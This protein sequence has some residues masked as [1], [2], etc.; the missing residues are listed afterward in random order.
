MF[1]L[2]AAILAHKDDNLIVVPL[3]ISLSA[4]KTGQNPYF[5]TNFYNADLV[6]GGNTYVR[7]MPFDISSIVTDAT[8]VQ[9]L[10]ITVQDQKQQLKAIQATEGLAN[11]HL[12]V[13]EAWVDSTDRATVLAA[14][15]IATGMIDGEPELD[16]EADASTAMI[17]I[18][19]GFVSLV[20]NAPRRKY[21]LSCTHDFGDA[22]CKHVVTA[23]QTCDHRYT[24]CLNTYANSI[25]FGGC[26][27]ALAPGTK[28]AIGGQA[29]P[30]TLRTRTY[31]GLVIHE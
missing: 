22:R 5:W 21:Q 13:Y 4:E 7:T 23:G 16:E 14:Q 28:V 11:R 27:H 24:T 20:V 6:Y 12:Q 26:R 15:M 2:P 10:T 19:Q 17:T 31:Y 30:A 1:D 3:L 29:A 25:N 18:N 9:T 8:G